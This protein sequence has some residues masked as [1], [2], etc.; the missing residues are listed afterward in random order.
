[1]SFSYD[2]MSSICGLTFCFGQK[3]VDGQN[4]LKH[5]IRRGKISKYIEGNKKISRNVQK[6]VNYDIMP[7]RCHGKKI[8]QER[9]PF[10]QNFRAEVRKFLGFEWTTTG[11]DGL[12]PF[13]SKNKFRP[14]N[15]DVGS[16]LLV[17]E[18]N[19]DF[20]GDINDIV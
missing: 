20:D 7:G 12:N 14:N 1:M 16:L 15:G 17:F 11:P 9:D 10:S 13:H 18:R 6:N 3:H 8:N 4:M 5:T 19:A 2:E